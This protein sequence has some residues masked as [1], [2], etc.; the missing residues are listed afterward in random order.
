MLGHRFYHSH[1]RKYVIL[2]GTLFNDLVIERD[3]ASA[4]LVQTL[5]VPISYGPAM[6][7][8]ARVE[9]DANLN[10][11]ASAILPRMS[12]EMTSMAYAPE[13]KMTSTQ[14][15]YHKQLVMLL[16]LNQYITQYR[17]ILFLI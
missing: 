13:R 5:A 6:K 2:F 16:V 8:L 10:R 14:R 3:D 7:T 9:Q 4:N 11:R 1:L 17:M 12:F 15:I